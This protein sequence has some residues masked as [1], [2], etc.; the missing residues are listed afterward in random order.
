VLRAA[1]ALADEAGI[2]SLTMRGLGQAL[3]V[4]A[5]S[6]YNHVANKDDLLDGMVDV[7][8]GDIVVPPSG[9]HWRSAMRARCISAH[10]TLL[11]HPWAAVQI[12]S[13]MTIGPG[14]IRYLDATLGRLR[15]GGFTIDGALD[16]WNA[17]DSHLY[18]FAL[19]ELNLPFA[20]EESSSVSASVL[21]Q[22]PAEEYPYVVE[23]LGHVM[24]QGRREDF[25]FGL[26]LILDGLERRLAGGKH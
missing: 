13:R 21:P 15:E 14:M 19:Q 26:D 17:L 20:V 4:E 12:T 3:G 25:E 7:V 16:A 6:L 11:A 9:T 22:I 10:Q 5:M 18:G 23:V 8:V 2:D 1:V 24:S